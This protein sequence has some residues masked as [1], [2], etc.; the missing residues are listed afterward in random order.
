M[1]A[2]VA[3]LVPSASAAI[4]SDRALVYCGASSVPCFGGFDQL[5]SGF[6]AAG[7]SGLDV[8]ASSLPWDL[9]P[10]RIILLMTPDF[11]LDAEFPLLEAFYSG[12]GVLVAVGEHSGFPQNTFSAINEFA[13]SLG[14]GISI[15]PQLISAGCGNLATVSSH[16]LMAGVTGLQ[17]AASS[18]VVGGSALAS[19]VNE[20]KTVLGIEGRLI[21]SGDSNIF[22]DECL[23]AGGE[24]FASNQNLRFIQNIFT[25]VPEPSAA[26]LMTFAL[27]GLSIW[28]RLT[29]GRPAAGNR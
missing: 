13:S 27:T 2:A 29:G 7:A 5:E 18:R 19:S 25:L 9:T 22:S 3:N 14:L 23:S 11:G 28:R 20:A 12:G 1:I 17:I 16:P 4:T 8:A 21:V 6:L 10:Y 15:D 26:M 24:A